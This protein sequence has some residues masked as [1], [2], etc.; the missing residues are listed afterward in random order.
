MIVEEK[1]FFSRLPLVKEETVSE[2]IL[3]HQKKQRK[4]TF[5]DK[6][7]SEIRSFCNHFPKKQG[8]S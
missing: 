3:T 6:I 7:G 5:I 1:D 8:P 2:I 4:Y